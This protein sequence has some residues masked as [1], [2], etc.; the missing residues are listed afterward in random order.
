MKP[1][2]NLLPVVFFLYFILP[3]GYLFAQHSGG[4]GNI[5]INATNFTAINLDNSNA[6]NKVFITDR[7]V[8]SNYQTGSPFVNTEW[9]QANIILIENKAEIL[10]VPVRIDAKANLLEINHEDRVKVLHA[11]NT[12][13]LAFKNSEE[14]FVSNKTLGVEEPEGFFKIVYNKKSS[15]LCHYSTKVVQGT[16]NPI[17]DAG[18]KEDKL[19]VEQTYYIFK[20]GKLV[21]LEKNRKKLIHQFNN[22]PEVAGFI[23]EQKITPKFE[24][25]LLKLV[26]FIDS[27][28]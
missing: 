8:N 24:Y 21:K 18:I 22:E 10:D 20:E 12:Y 28:S 6:W 7:P 5:S 16:Y 19:V 27:H 3:S 13:S 9:Q 23:R 2:K 4:S 26:S 1:L 17:L 11:T 15:L 14:V 25:D